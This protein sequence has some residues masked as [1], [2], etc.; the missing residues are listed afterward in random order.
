M[1]VVKLQKLGS[2]TGVIV[3]KELLSRF[4][5]S[6]GDEL[7]LVETERGFEFTPYDPEFERQIDVARE[8]MR[9]DRNALRKL[10]Q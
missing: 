3:P 9:E 7:Y 5:L 8:V 1:K 6:R 4:Q 2:S 10:G